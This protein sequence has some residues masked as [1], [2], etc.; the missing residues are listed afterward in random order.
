MWW[1]YPSRVTSVPSA[2][3]SADWPPLLCPPSPLEVQ[4]LL[5]HPQ[6]SLPCPAPLPTLPLSCA[7]SSESPELLALSARGRLLACDLDLINQ[8]VPKGGTQ[9]IPDL[10][11]QITTTSEKYVPAGAGKGAR[12]VWPSMVKSNPEAE[13]RDSR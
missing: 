6:A 11:A 2:Q 5:T 9:H 3:A 8:S 1:A 13:A 7:L 4:L 10:L 12:H